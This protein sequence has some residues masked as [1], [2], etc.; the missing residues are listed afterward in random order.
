MEDRT[1]SQKAT[2]FRLVNLWTA[3]LFVAWLAVACYGIAY[4]ASH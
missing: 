1:P 3:G 2:Q 4:L